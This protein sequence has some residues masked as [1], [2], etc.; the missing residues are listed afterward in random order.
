M[1]RYGQGYDRGM[2]GYDRGFPQGYGYPRPNGQTGYGSYGPARG[3]DAGFGGAR[4][5]AM[6][7]RGGYD[8]GF[9]GG[10]GYDRQAGMR[11]GYDGRNGMRG[12][13]S[14]LPNRVTARYNMDYVHPQGERRPLNY[15]SFGGDVEGRVVDSR[16]Y[17]GPYLTSGG[18]MT[19]RGGSRPVGW[20][21]DFNRTRGYDGFGGPGW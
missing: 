18:S 2:R 20:E 17:S 4:S 11:G 5:G 9:R 1:D 14:W 6:P 8:R 3:Y 21:N 10:P 16:E 19:W 13:G 7:P 12:A 15:T